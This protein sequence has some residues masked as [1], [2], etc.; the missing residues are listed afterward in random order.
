MQKAPVI[1]LREEFVVYAHSAIF[2]A[3][4]AAQRDALHGQSS[5]ISLWFVFAGVQKASS[6]QSK[7]TG[8]FISFLIERLY[9]A[10]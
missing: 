1:K 8:N 4:Y 3:R 7:R 6:S 5:Q 10:P 2:G 9:K